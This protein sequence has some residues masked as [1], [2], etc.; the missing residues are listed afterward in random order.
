MNL[1]CLHTKF[2]CFILHP[3]PS[4][5]ENVRVFYT[6]ITFTKV[7][8]LSKFYCLTSSKNVEIAPPPH[9]FARRLGFIQ[10]EDVHAKLVNW[11]KGS[12]RETCRHTQRMAILFAYFRSLRKKKRQTKSAQHTNSHIHETQPRVQPIRPI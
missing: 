2:Q 9:T 6:N 7:T 3:Q 1:F 11:L 5:T 10:R 12:S 4:T 8:Y